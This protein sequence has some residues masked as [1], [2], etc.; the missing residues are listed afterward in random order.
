MTE[1][2]IILTVS[3]LFLLTTDVL[4]ILL[5][6]AIRSN[7]LNFVDNLQKKLKEKNYFFTAI[8]SIIHLLPYK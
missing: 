3:E 7:D 2:K 1:S 8:I 5:Q 6:L 4:I